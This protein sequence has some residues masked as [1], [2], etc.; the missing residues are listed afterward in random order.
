LP[1][2]YFKSYHSYI[3]AMEQ[4]N[5]TECGRLYRACLQYSKLGTVP[6]LRG[7][8][9]FIFPSMKSQIDRDIESY[10]SLCETNRQNGSLG[11]QAN[12]TERYR[13]LPN[14]GET[15]KEKAKEKIKEKTKENTGDIAHPRFTPPTIEEVRAYCQERGNRVDPQRFIDFY[16]SNG[17]KVGKNQMK[18][19]QA[20]VRTW[21]KGESQAKPK[22]Y[23]T[24]E[25]HSKAVPSKTEVAAAQK[26]LEK[27]RAEE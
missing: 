27:L 5:D 19:W 24:A 2:E 8:E 6:E 15:D 4:L 25:K 10:K 1:R 7:N 23:T 13:T 17:W 16:T 11:G 14:G 21:E 9:R 3:E 26:F 22:S 20:S 12:A 18:D